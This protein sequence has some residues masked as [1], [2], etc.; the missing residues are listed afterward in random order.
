L[1]HDQLG[2]REAVENP[3]SK[4]NVATGSMNFFTSTPWC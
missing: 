1:D 2:T 4:G 3:Y